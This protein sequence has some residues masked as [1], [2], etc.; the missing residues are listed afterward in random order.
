MEQIVK[1]GGVTRGWV[2]VEVQ[3]L[4]PELAESFNLKDVK[5]GALIA[6]V[7]KGGPADLGGVQ[8]GDVLLAVNGSPVKDS[9]SLLNLIAALKPA[10]ST[11]LTVARKNQSLELQ[12]K[13]GRRPAQSPATPDS[14]N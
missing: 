7:L 9:S 6:G 14:E 4:S 12:I 8:P 11:H 1:D 2:G 5:E 10:D 13:V 3:D